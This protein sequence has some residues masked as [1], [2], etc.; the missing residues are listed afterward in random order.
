MEKPISTSQIME[1]NYPIGERTEIAPGFYQVPPYP[2]A[3]IAVMF[4]FVNEKPTYQIK[5]SWWSLD[6]ERNIHIQFNNQEKERYI[7]LMDKKYAGE[8]LSKE[9]NSELETL[10]A[11]LVTL[12]QSASEQAVNKYGDTIY[13]KIITG[14]EKNEGEKEKISAPLIKLHKPQKEYFNVSK[15]VS[16]LTTNTGIIRADNMLQ[17]QPLKKKNV[18]TTIDF[19]NDPH[20]SLTNPNVTAYDM[21]LIDAAVTLMINGYWIF[22]KEMLVRVKDGNFDPKKKI[23]AQKLGACTKSLEKTRYIGLRINCQQELLARR[24]ITQADIDRD[25]NIGIFEGYLMPIENLPVAA[26]NGNVMLDGIQLL[27]EPIIYS[28]SRS[29]K[30]IASV[31]TEILE[32]QASTGMSDT[33]DL[34]SLKRYLIKRIEAMRNSKNNIVSRRIRLEWHDSKTD[35][36]K[37]LLHD[38]GY[39]K[40]EYSN[41]R[42]KK[43]QIC[44][45]I[46]GLLTSFQ[47]AKYIKGFNTVTEKQAIVGFDI[48]L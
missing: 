38:L 35:T 7:S 14:E 18:V 46:N 40:S 22:S 2:A 9:D 32:T 3:I 5:E 11:L 48:Q 26:G 16:T 15:L 20:L 30:Q 25:P 28:Y 13:K 6:K 42:K 37:G 43:S 44:N 21:D 1:I 36:D 31:P 24:I 45:T 33:D 8:Q 34:V 39:D 4:D 17:L 23:S 19:K 27:K 10:E 41:W 29:I 12:P 47:T